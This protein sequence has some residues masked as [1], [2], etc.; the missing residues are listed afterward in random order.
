V[1]LDLVFNL[2]CAG[3][4]IYAF[5]RSASKDIE[6]ARL[7]DELDKAYRHIASLQ[8]AVELVMAR[9]DTAPQP[10]DAKE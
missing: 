1:I 10:R 4:T 5:I 7:R 3:V 6:R 2:L 8:R 9:I